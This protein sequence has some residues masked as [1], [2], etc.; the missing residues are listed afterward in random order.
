MDYFRKKQLSEIDE[1]LRLFDIN[2]Y[3]AFDA[4]PN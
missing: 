4:M 2:S 1:I 3:S